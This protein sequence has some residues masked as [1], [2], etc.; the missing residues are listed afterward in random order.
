MKRV[1]RRS[2]FETNSSSMHSIV[3]MKNDVNTENQNDDVW[4]KDGKLQ[5][6]NSDLRFGRT[7]FEILSTTERK[8]HYAIASSALTSLHVVKDG[9]CDEYF[10][11]KLREFDSIASK[12]FENCVGI[13]YPTIPNGRNGKK[14][15]QY[16]LG[17]VDHD[18]D[19]L[20]SRFLEEEN[21]S[22]YEF[23]SNPKYIVIIDGDEYCIFND[24]KKSGLIQTDNIIKEYCNNGYSFDYVHEDDRKRDSFV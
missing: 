22:L 10:S 12:V 16:N 11:N 18:S 15:E 6:F 4:I 14:W 2:V 9:N 24:L 20:L 8:L 17:Y 23:I 13:N 21:I 3:V 5:V 7:P 19:T 1:I